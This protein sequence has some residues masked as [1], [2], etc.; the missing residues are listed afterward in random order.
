MA[1]TRELAEAVITALYA[2]EQLPKTLREL[3]ITARKFYEYVDSNPELASNLARAEQAWA[4]NMASEIVSI[5]D[6]DPDAQRARNRIDARKWVA[7]KLYASKF[8]ERI[9]LNLTG[10]V[11]LTAAIAAGRQ[12]L[13]LPQSPL[14][15]T[16]TSRQT[17]DYQV[18]DNI[19]VPK[20]DSTTNVTESNGASRSES[21]PGPGGEDPP[22]SEID[23][24]LG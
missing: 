3:G 18:S 4:Q 15:V 22:K 11:D 16:H 5:A 21:L 23:D 14:D 20:L 13:E 12:R 24:I 10:T 6:E 2:G 7:S 9:D 19:E 17:F 8:G 1:I